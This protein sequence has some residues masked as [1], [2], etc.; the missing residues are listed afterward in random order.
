MD[1]SKSAQRGDIWA[2]DAVG[3][4]LFQRQEKGVV[5]I[6]P[7]PMWYA[8]RWLSHSPLDSLKHLRV[9]IPHFDMNIDLRNYYTTFRETEKLLRKTSSSIKSLVIIFGGSTRHHCSQNGPGRIRYKFTYLPW[10]IKMA[11]ILLKRLLLAL[12]ECPFTILTPHVRG[13]ST[14]GKRGGWTGPGR[15]ISV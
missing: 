5:A 10:C 3:E 12:S 9:T 13:L 8:L 1:F 4:E 14:A 6:F 11:G 2:E 7:G 15:H